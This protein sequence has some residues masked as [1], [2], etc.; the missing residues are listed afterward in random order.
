MHLFFLILSLLLPKYT[1]GGDDCQ[2]F[3]SELV[4]QS[5]D[6]VK[7]IKNNLSSNRF[8]DRLTGLYELRDLKP[9]GEYIYLEILPLIQDSYPEVRVEAVRI[10]EEQDSIYMQTISALHLQLQR[11]N[12]P[13][14]YKVIDEVLNTIYDQLLRKI[15][16]M[17]ERFEEPLRALNF[18]I[19]KA[20]HLVGKLGFTSY[21]WLEITQRS[22]AKQPERRTT[23]EELALEIYNE[24]SSAESRLK[25]IINTL[26][27]KSS[28]EFFYIYFKLSEVYR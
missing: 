22:L 23:I 12:D 15:Q 13:Y 25:A 18:N 28:L 20:D 1:Y 17:R 2:D 6:F 26:P 3:I 9:D 16:R 21:Q 8:E 14:V 19:E 7:E 11:E 27:F 10:L 24:I 4:D 5:V